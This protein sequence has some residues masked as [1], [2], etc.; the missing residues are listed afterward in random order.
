M[1]RRTNPG[2]RLLEIQQAST[3]VIDVFLTNS[4]KNPNGEKVAKMLSTYS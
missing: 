1:K 4:K 3:N 2:V